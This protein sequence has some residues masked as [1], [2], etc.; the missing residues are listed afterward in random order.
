LGQAAGTTLAPKSI[1]LLAITDEPSK[2]DYVKRTQ[3]QPLAQPSF[4]T[5]MISIKETLDEVGGW[6]AEPS[7]TALSASCLPVCLCEVLQC[8]AWAAVVFAVHLTSGVL[9]K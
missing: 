1:D 3:A 2:Q 5:C 4:I 8:V 9:H 7:V 6:H